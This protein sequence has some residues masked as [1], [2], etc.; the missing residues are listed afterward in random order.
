M[1]GL[2]GDKKGSLSVL[3]GS[4]LTYSLVNIACGFV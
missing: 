4:F 3:F 1:T 2:Q